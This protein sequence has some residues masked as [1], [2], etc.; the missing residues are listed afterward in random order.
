MS[1]KCE[2]TGTGPIVG[3]RVSHSN[4]KTLR[5]Y[6]PNLV[7]VTLHSETL[8]RGFSLRVVAKALRTVDK[9]G[10]LDVYLM[11]A[12]EK[13]L[14]PAAVKIKRQLEKAAEAA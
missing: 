7:D 11:K 2:L 14:S 10:G 6:L 13:V 4:I 12:D 3:N 8:N 5:R 1:R 9:V